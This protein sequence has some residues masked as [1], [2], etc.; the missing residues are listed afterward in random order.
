M[1]IFNYIVTL[2]KECH[3]LKSSSI[4]SNPCKA[5][6]SKAVY[7]LDNLVNLVKNMS[8]HEVNA[9]TDIDQQ[10]EEESR[11]H[12][13]RSMTLKHEETGPSNGNRDTTSLLGDQTWSKR[14]Q[15]DENEVNEVSTRRRKL[16]EKGRAYRA[17]LL[18]ER[19]EKING[20]MMRKCS[21]IV[22]LLRSN[23]NRIAV[24]EELAQF[25][26]LLKMLLNIHEEYSQVLDDDK[27]AGE[28]D[29]FDDLDD[30]VCTFKRK[31]HNWLRSAAAE[32]RSSKGSSR[33]SESG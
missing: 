26:D 12:Q 14:D 1:C 27:G 16:T 4:Y 7:K 31:I 23:K 32:R 18:K 29:W 17:V 10:T 30:K 9:A 3:I 11:I 22:D 5:P 33:S 2:L 21:I 24:Q 15:A 13:W 19:R 25:N 28:N 6:T 20:R 8:F